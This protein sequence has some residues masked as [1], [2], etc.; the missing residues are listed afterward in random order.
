MLMH[1]VLCHI[2]SHHVMCVNSQGIVMT[3]GYNQKRRELGPCWI[4]F[5]TIH[6]LDQALVVIVTQQITIEYICY[7]YSDWSGEEGVTIM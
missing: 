7:C 5:G 1:H 2:L 4:S 3:N 6:C